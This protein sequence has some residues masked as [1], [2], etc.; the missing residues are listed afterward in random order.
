MKHAQAAHWNLR[1]TFLQGAGASSPKSPQTL[2]PHS[3]AEGGEANG[4][5]SL[6][7]NVVPEES[8]FIRQEPSCSK[9]VT[10]GPF[11]LFL[12][13][14]THHNWGVKSKDVLN[15]EFPPT[16]SWWPHVS[17]EP[18]AVRILSA[19]LGL[20]SVI[21]P[22]RVSIWFMSAALVLSLVA[23]CRSRFD[24]AVRHLLVHGIYDNQIFFFFYHTLKHS[25]AAAMI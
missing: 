1:N 16:H 6:L 9:T 22:I 21:L 11:R 3:W 4:S 19:P 18:R 17:K 10:R 5:D 2:L 15:S 24:A 8:Y 14:G 12:K 23:Q 13:Q 20:V 7:W 25:S